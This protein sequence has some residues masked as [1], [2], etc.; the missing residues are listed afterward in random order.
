[1][2]QSKRARKRGAPQSGSK[3]GPAMVVGALAVASVIVWG[4]TRDAVAAHHPEPHPHASAEHVVEPERYAGYPR[5]AEVYRQ[6]AAIP[7]VLDGLYCHCEC[8][9][10]AN[11]R[12]LL[13]CFESDHGANCDVCLLEAEL[14]YRMTRDGKNLNEIR[15]AIDGLYGG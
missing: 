5:I 4:A 10:H 1:M 11:H 7:H 2:G 9:K 14:A 15:A 6:A 12:S 8:S 13:E 3:A